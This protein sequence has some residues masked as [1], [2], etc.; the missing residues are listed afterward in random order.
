M[1]HESNC[2]ERIKRVF[3]GAW[4][5]ANLVKHE[6]YNKFEESYV[7]YCLSNYNAIVDSVLENDKSKFHIKIELLKF[8]WRDYYVYSI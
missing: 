1:L 7:R 8:E 4:K 5:T 2:D 3:S 6:N